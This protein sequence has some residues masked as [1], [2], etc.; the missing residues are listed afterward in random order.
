MR[1]VQFQSTDKC[2]PKL[3]QEMQRTS[4]KGHMAP[5][6]LSA[7]Q[8]ADGLVNHCLENRGGEILLGGPFVDERLNICLGKNTAA[9]GDGV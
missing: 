7:G 9:G 5:N 8:S 2:L 1:I 6:G 3:R 4:Q